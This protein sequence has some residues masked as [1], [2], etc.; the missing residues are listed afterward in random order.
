MSSY[1]IR[2]IAVPAAFFSISYPEEQVWN[3]T[4]PVKIDLVLLAT[5]M[6]PHGHTLS[7]APALSLLLI[8][9]LFPKTNILVSHCW[10]F[11]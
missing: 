7:P 9:S 3:K 10:Y 1:N 5:V 6:F 8:P 11:G 2:L 4:L